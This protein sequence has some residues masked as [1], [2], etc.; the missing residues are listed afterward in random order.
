M[1]VAVGALSPT[2][3]AYQNRPRPRA[4]SPDIVKIKDNLYVIGGSQPEFQ[5]TFTGG[6]TAVWITDSGIVLVDQKN[7]TW[8]QTI[9]DK[10]KTATDEPVVML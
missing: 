4:K 6:N 3:A 7:P 9:L 8:G 1:F 5:H 2:V 10:V